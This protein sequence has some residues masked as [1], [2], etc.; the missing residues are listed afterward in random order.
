MQRMQRVAGGATPLAIVGVIVLVLVVGAIAWH[1]G[2]P[3]PGGA[4]AGPVSLSHGADG[5]DTVELDGFKGKLTVGVDASGQITATAQPDAVFRLDAATH[6]LTLTC[7]GADPAACPSA[8]LALLVPAHVGLT[9]HELSGQ[10][11]LTG[12]SGPVVITATSADTTAVA[13]DTSDFT[14]TVTSGTLDAGFAA[15]PAHVAVS[16][17]SAQ[18]AVHLPGGVAYDVRQQSVSADIQ[19]DVP[20]SAASAHTVQA[21]ATSGSIELTTGG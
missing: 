17:T 4:P 18:A 7:A 8:N 1:S 19:V 15:A 11:T 2:R 9:L 10:A 21:T 3:A 14:A 20:Q 12:L 6:V 5:V 16:V 13:L